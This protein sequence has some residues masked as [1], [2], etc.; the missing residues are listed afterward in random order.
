MRRQLAAGYQ[1]LLCLLLP[2]SVL[3]VPLAREQFCQLQIYP[4]NHHNTFLSFFYKL[5]IYK[6]ERTEKGWS[7][8]SSLC[9]QKAKFSTCHSHSLHFPLGCKHPIC[10]FLIIHASTERFCMVLIQWCDIF[11][12]LEMFGVPLKVAKSFC[13][14]PACKKKAFEC[15]LS[16]RTATSSRFLL[17]Y[18]L[19]I[20]NHLKAL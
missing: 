9:K 17:L 12:V 1:C 11:F 16:K 13:G 14:G 15:W 8:S 3:H 6:Y 5:N 10:S 2:H 20:L 19:C 18:S 4:L 7:M